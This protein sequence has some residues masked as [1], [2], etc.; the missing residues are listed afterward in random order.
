MATST[1]GKNANNIIACLT[2]RQQQ[3]SKNPLPKS[4][5]TP[6]V[7]ILHCQTFA[8]YG[9]ALYS[10]DYATKFFSWEVL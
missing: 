2:G 6:F 9:I 4:L 7:K 10:Y 8:P 3:L 5:I 1:C